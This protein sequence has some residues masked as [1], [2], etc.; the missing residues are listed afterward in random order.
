MIQ[1]QSDSEQF[2]VWQHKPW[3]CQPWSILLTGCG[4]IAGSWLLFHRY[5]LT[6]IVALP[7]GTWMIFFIGVYPKLIAG[8]IAAE[9]SSIK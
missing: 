1:K 2:D 9:Q 6:G 8:A 4:A 3:W 7:M 5:W